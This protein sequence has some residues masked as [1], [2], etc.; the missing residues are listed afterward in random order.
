LEKVKI[1]TP[2]WRRCITIAQRKGKNIV[3]S[4]LKRYSRK[5]VGVNQGDK[6]WYKKR[7]KR[8]QKSDEVSFLDRTTAAKRNLYLLHFLYRVSTCNHG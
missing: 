3:S 4:L 2:T 5:G 7:G 8:Q 1:S 6:K